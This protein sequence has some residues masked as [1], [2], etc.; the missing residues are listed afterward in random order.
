MTH[1]TIATSM[2]TT[3]TLSASGTDEPRR[4]TPHGRPEFVLFAY[5]V[6]LLVMFNIAAGGLTGPAYQ[7]ILQNGLN[8]KP[9]TQSVFGLLTDMPNIFG[10][11]FG[12]L[13]D[14]WKPFKRGDRGYF[15]FVPLLM[16]GINFML[17]SGPFTYNRLLWLSILG[18]ATGALLGA[19]V[20]G[21]LTAIAQYNGTAG[22]F[23]VLF[24]V[25]PRLVGIVSNYIGGKLGDASHQHLAFALSGFLCFP[26]SALAL[27][28]P[29]VAFAQELDPAIH[30][31]LESIGHA[32]RRLIRHR[33]IYMPAIILSLWA[34]APGWGTPLNVY[35]IKKIGLSEA[36][37]GNVMATLGIGTLVSS[38]GYVFLCKHLRLRPLLY[39]GTILGVLGCPVFLLIHSPLQAYVYGFLAG[40]SLSVGLCSFN[41][42]LIRCC[43]TDLEGV[44]FLLVIAA[45]SLATDTS[46]LFGA[47][48]YEKGGF[49]LA[50][51]ATTATTGAILFVLPFVPH[52]VT[53]HREGERL[54]ETVV[55]Q[56]A[57]LAPVAS[58]E[59]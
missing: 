19:A 6:L 13:R 27:W 43:P 40:V 26:M 14:R 29:R 45:R 25:V 50:L 56:D 33:A 46:D 8:L 49:G 41:D 44:A 10:F 35:L 48:L 2:T 54:S 37:Y 18:A 53:A 39:W 15:L 23:S 21:L 38:L 11:V 3:D 17:A 42:L 32:I 52:A 58:S 16:A 51:A 4:V 31:S 20:N 9:T 30:P 55:E 36:S 47:W 24:L 57:E 7:S 34:F 28:R 22:R 1:V 12:F 59:G 5:T